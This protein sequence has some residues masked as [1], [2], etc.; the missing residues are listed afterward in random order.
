LNAKQEPHNWDQSLES[1]VN[2][3][4]PL[5]DAFILVNVE[6]FESMRYYPAH[7][8][9]SEDAPYYGSSD[10]AHRIRREISRN[11]NY[12]RIPI[13]GMTGKV[14]GG[15]SWT[16][17]Y[18][19]NTKNAT[20]LRQVKSNWINFLKLWQCGTVTL[21]SIPL[22]GPPLASVI[23]QYKSPSRMPD[24]S[25]EDY[26][27]MTGTPVE[28]DTEKGVGIERTE[29]CPGYNTYRG[30]SESSLIMSR[31]TMVNV[32]FADNVISDGNLNSWTVTKRIP[33]METEFPHDGP[34]R[35]GKYWET[36]PTRFNVREVIMSRD[37]K[38][39]IKTIV[40]NPDVIKIRA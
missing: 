26:Q 2:D 3:D 1:E 10:K 30:I 4:V 33:E 37:Y 40:S 31:L 17:Y 7:N 16:D 15:D 20:Y 25:L 9:G 34:I 22:G 6:E 19:I 28:P 14:A 8:A 13:G 11:T 32:N 12:E 23:W 21:D 5:S 36:K 35:Y 18:L 24:G 38:S 27:H 39:N 29:E